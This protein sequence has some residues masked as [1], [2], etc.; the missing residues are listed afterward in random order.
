[1]KTFKREKTV[2]N[3]EADGPF[4]RRARGYV[5]AYH[6]R[7]NGDAARHGHLVRRFPK[8]AKGKA[9]VKAAKRARQAKAA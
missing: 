4:W 7:A 3:G 2:R 5:L 9:A 8:L 6:R 1:M